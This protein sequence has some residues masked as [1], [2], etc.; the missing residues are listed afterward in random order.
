MVIIQVNVSIVIWDS[1]AITPFINPLHS[2][3]LSGNF[4]PGYVF[5][6]RFFKVNGKTIIPCTLN[7]WTFPFLIFWPK[8]IMH[9]SLSHTCYMLGPSQPS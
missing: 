1:I 8:V 4:N 3:Q 6:H 7:T 2:T 9:F 5:T